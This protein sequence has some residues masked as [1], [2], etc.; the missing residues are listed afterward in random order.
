MSEFQQP[1]SGQ[2]T[3][4]SQN[5]DLTSPNSGTSIIQITGTWIGTIVLQGS[6]NGITYITLQVVEQN[7]NLHKTSMLTNGIFIGPTNGFQFLR[8][9]TT[10]WTSGSAD[11]SVYGSDAASVIN[12][13][14]TITGASDGTKIGNVG[15][16][17]FTNLRDE[18][19]IAFGTESNPFFINGQSEVLSPLPG[20]IARSNKVLT[21]GA[22]Q[23]DTYTMTDDIAVVDFHFGG[24]GIGQA[25]LL[26]LDNSAVEFVPGGGF[27]SSSDVNMWTNAGNGSSALLTWTYTTAQFFEG[28]GSATL[29]FTQSDTN[30]FPAI[31]YTWSTPKDVSAWNQISAH[32][33]VTVAGGGSQSRR[34]QIVMTDI[35]AATRTWEIVGTTTTPPFNTEQWLQILGTIS[36]PNSETGTFDPYN[37][38]SITLRLLDGGNKSGTIY[39]D[40]VRFLESRTLIER[41]YTSANDTFQLILNPVELFDTGD[42]LGL[43]FKNN[44]TV[45]REYTVTA[46]G[47]IR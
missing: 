22:T 25:S 5:I 12:S 24:R 19:G 20:F 1:I 16:S 18:S 44:D 34:V 27:N 47:V 14:S 32:V 30:N 8:L 7:S 23:L 9:Y 41:I 37:V 43:E 36:S 4:A 10:T 17:L 26:R 40:N 29:T 38:S 13:L 2:F 31:R 3:G 35:N 11:I 33:R 15:S 28:S 46:K 42:I 39:W 21:A 6:N 45:A